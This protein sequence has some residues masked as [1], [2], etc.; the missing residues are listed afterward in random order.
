MDTMNAISL[1]QLITAIRNAES[2]AELQRLVGPSE[3]EEARA[4]QRM[5]QIDAMWDRCNGDLSTLAVFTKER[6][7][8]L[9]LEQTEFEN[10][11]C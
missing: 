3:E 2:L 1:S 5:S 4:K 7:D 10:K 8:Q 6:Y 9:M 11:Y